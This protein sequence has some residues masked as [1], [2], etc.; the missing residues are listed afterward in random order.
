MTLDATE[1]PLNLALGLTAASSHYY[2]VYPATVADN[3]D[4]DGQGR[5]RLGQDGEE[6]PFLALGQPRGPHLDRRV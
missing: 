5:V 6:L 3:Q 4:P 2:G 1:I